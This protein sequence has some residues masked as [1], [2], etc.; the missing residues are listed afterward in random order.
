MT[1][2]Q[3]SAFIQDHIHFHIQAI[4]D[5]VCLQTLDLLDGFGEAHGEVEEN[6]ALVGG[7]GAA[8]EVAD[9][10]CGGSGPSDYDVEGEEETTEGVEP[11]Y[12]EVESDC[13]SDFS[14]SIWVYRSEI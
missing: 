9:V 5:V 6:V 13:E 2:P 4:T 3:T 1:I 8:T 14:V 12:F 11:P 7:G 10:P